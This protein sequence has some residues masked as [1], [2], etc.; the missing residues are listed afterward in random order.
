MPTL[1]KLLL[2][3]NNAKVFTTPDAKD[4]FYQISVDEQSSKLTTFWTSFDHYRY[5]RMPFGVNTAPEEFQR[6][7]KNNLLIYQELNSYAMTCWS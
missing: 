7:Y 2:E 6:D 3:L 4:G 5:L 1:D